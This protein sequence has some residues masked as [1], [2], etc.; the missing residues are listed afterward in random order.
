VGP[1]NAIS[2]RKGSLK[3]MLLCGSDLLE[4]FRCLDTRSG[5]NFANNK[6]P[7]LLLLPGQNHMQGKERMPG[8]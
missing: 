5:N 1:R 3:V 7:H 4:S 6:L 2:L 8:S